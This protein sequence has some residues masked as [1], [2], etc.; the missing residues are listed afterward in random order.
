MKINKE[1]LTQCIARAYTH[2]RNARKPLDSYLIEAITKEVKKAEE[3][4]EF[5]W[6]R[7]PASDRVMLA[8]RTEAPVTAEMRD[9]IMNSQVIRLLHAG[10]GLA[11]EAGEFLD[12]LKRHIFYGKPLD[13]T[14]LME[15]MGD[16]DWYMNLACDAL[17]TTMAVIEQA[18][19][20]KLAAR[21]GE[22]FS[23]DAALLRNLGLELKVLEDNLAVNNETPGKGDM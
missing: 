6:D 12:Q 15:E 11:T 13:K 1:V 16:T 19:I 3:R 8:T 20:K 2:E 17:H 23:E 5:D 7:V 4:G 14:N 9:R 10:I 21:Y 18:N 22:K